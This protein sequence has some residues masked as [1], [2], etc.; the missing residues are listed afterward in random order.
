M[1][2]VEARRT[3]TLTV[4]APAK[5]NLTLRILGKRTDNYHDL[6]TLFQSIDLCDRLRFAFL[7]SDKDE[8][9]IGLQDSTASHD[10]PLN[11]TNIIKK[12]AALYMRETTNRSPLKVKVRVRKNI[13]IGA[14]LA[15]GSANAA[16]TLLAI[17][18]HYGEKLSSDQLLQLAAEIGSDVPF[19]LRGGTS[20]GRGRG[21]ILSPLPVQT[22]LSF[23]LVKP[24][25]LSVSTAW[26]YE[27]FG[28]TRFYEQLDA[29]TLENQIEKLHSLLG[30]RNISAAA[31]LF[32]N[33]FE[34]VVFERYPVL[35]KIKER[36]IELGC[37]C[38][39]MTGSGP[40]VY[41]LA[42]GEAPAETI[43]STIISDQESKTTH[44]WYKD[45]GLAVD[46]W[47]V[48]SIGHGIKVI[49]DEEDHN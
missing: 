38:A 39:Y 24:K 43:R 42:R 36:L 11:D 29:A 3:Q 31:K 35:R 44:S 47:L 14:G 17:N 16:A 34:T 12:A 19:S 6:F 27:S 18:H 5:L 21:E 13:P 7:E 40:T 1:K 45:H 23:V 30:A 22:D 33:S 48:K 25:A 15:G 37:L 41:G 26:A 2:N 10:F 20:L 32:S 28:R 46:T 8:V 49:E 9:E 4:L